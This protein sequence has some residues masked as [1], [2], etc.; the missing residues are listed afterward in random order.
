MALMLV[1]N[2]VRDYDAWREVF[3]AESSRL[4]G[5]ELEVVHVWRSHDDPNEVHFLLRIGDMEK[6]KAFVEDPASAE[7]GERA[8]VLEGEIR[9]VDDVT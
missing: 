3:D 5:A 6:A 7:A 9:Y 1:R 2:S 8:G 4:H